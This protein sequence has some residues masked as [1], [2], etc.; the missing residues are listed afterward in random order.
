V[1]STI[2]LITVLLG[3][4]L[5]F[6][7][8]GCKKQNS[9]T[10]TPKNV[11][12]A[13][14]QLRMSLDNASPEVKNIFYDKVENGVRYGKYPDAIAALDQLVAQPGVTDKQKKLATQLSDM[15]KSKLATPTNA[16]RAATS[17]DLILGS[18][19]NEGFHASYSM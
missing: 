4:L 9:F 13:S 12:E 16:G 8:S 11:E 10:G 5:C 19:R 17:V 3:G 15:L 14:L 2:W 1:K 7:A 18:A 6:S